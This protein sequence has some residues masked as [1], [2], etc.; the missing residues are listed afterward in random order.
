MLLQLLPIVLLFLCFAV[1]FFASLGC[2]SESA[3]RHSRLWTL[4]LA[5]ARYTSLTRKSRS[6]AAIFIYAMINIYV[7]VPLVCSLL[8]LRV[9]IRRA[10]A[11][12]L[13]YV[14]VYNMSHP[15]KSH[16]DHN[17]Y[18]IIAILSC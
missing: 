16:L 2:S 18:Y 9:N 12:L 8:L 15:Q 7:C 10:N 1:V 5:A 4:A 11:F 14:K 17:I 13:M 3:Q 6:A